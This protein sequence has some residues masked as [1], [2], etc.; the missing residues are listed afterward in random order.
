VRFGWA[1][2]GVAVI[3]IVGGCTPHP[4]DPSA[5]GGSPSAAPSGQASGSAPPWTEPGAYEFVLQ[6]GCDAN[7][8]LA[9]YRVTVKGGS[10]VTSERIDRVAAP[11]ASADVDL[12]PVT[13][14]DGEEIEVPSLRELIDMARTAA[15]DG[16]EASTTYDA[17]DGH[18]VSVTINVSDEGPSGAECFTVSDY[19][20]AS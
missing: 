20:P 12:G 17:K 4:A 2:G 11:E 15:D 16:G 9:R 10:V 19:A 8:P 1:L 6:R 13:G 5:G 14:E 7:A 3:A 18:P